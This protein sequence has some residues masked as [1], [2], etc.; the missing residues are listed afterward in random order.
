MWGQWDRR[1]R[2]EEDTGECQ[3]LK[4]WKD[5]VAAVGLFAIIK[6]RWGKSVRNCVWTY[7]RRPPCKIWHKHGVCRWMG[8]KERK[9]KERCCWVHILIQSLA[10]ITFCAC[11]AKYFNW[12]YHLICWFIL[13]LLLWSLELILLLLLPTFS[14]HLFPFTILW[15]LVVF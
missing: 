7:K 6:G 2:C 11:S 12:P 3:L 9:M 10:S 14:F 15:L 13:L 4:C 8:W 5:S 1:T